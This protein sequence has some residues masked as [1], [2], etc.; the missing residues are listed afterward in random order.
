VTDRLEIRA[1]EAIPVRISGSRDFRISEGQTRTHTSVVLRLLTEDDRV[2]GIAEIVCAPPG[3]PEELP[4]EIL[5]AVRGAVTP[6]LVGVHVADRNVAC[7]RLERDLKERPWTKA[8]VNVA[9]HDVQARSL[10]VPVTDLL[11]GRMNGRIP[12]IGPVV[13]IMS[14][15]EMA[16][17]AAAEVDAG[18]QAVKIKVGESILNDIARV[19]AVREAIGAR[20]AL[21]V[22]AN[23]HYQPAD[24]IRLIK[25]IE[26]Y[27]I[28]HVEQPVARRDILGMQT[29]RK[30]VGVP[31]MTD[32]MVATPREAMNVI[33]LGAADR[34]KVK[35]TKHGLDGARLITEMLAA[36]GMKAVLGHVFELGLAAAAE[37]QFAACASNLAPPHE[38]GSMQPMGTAADIIAEDLW[39]ERG[40]IRIPDGPGL[41]VRLD[42]EKVAELRVDA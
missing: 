4:E 5:A 18:F 6:A 21:R 30:A 39:T 1:V 10:G 36:A 34:M 8:A 35:V 13:G 33:R 17:Q 20:A 37:G 14:P 38:I 15:E 40:F 26:D 11:G 12:V 27:D 28:E 7:A 25:A 2:Q 16:R 41:G 3:K 9:L 24:A 23:D 42:P 22:D 31:L 29:V 32:D 19:A